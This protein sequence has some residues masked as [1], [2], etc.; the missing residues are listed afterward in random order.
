[1]CGKSR[2]EKQVTVGSPVL[3]DSLLGFA[4]MPRDVEKMEPPLLQ[5]K[6]AYLP[7]PLLLLRTSHIQFPPPTTIGLVVS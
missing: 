3:F 6:E 1:M 7:V 4:Q 2:N 5:F